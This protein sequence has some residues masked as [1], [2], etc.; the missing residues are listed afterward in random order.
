MGLGPVIFRFYQGERYEFADEFCPRCGYDA[1]VYVDKMGE[2][3][4]R[5]CFNCGLEYLI[6]EEDDFETLPDSD[7]ST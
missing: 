6:L 4:N 3:T 5:V 7:E 2:N 1:G